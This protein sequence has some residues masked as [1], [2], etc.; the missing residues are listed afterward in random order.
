VNPEGRQTNIGRQVAEELTTTL[1]NRGVAVVERTLLDKVLV[2]LAVQHVSLFD[3]KTAQQVGRQVGAYAALIG[4]V[5]PKPHAVEVQARLVKVDT[6]EILVAASQVM[7]VTRVTVIDTPLSNASSSSS[8][9]VNGSR[10]RTAEGYPLIAGVWR[11]GPPSIRHK[12]TISQTE[13]RFTAHLVCYIIDGHDLQ[14]PLE[15]QM[16]GT[17]SKNGDISATARN[18]RVPSDWKGFGVGAI[19]Q[20]RAG[21]LDKSGTIVH[22]AIKHRG[23]QDSFCDFTWTLERR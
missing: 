12:V 5:L 4:T 23:E 18:T 14:P 17:I 10:R 20:T 15:Q 2:E 13:G 9:S 21:V 22:G 19:A 11:E 3:P 8:A 7:T 6:G 1:V 16:K